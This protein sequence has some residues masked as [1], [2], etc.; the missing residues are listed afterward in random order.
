METLKIEKK[1]NEN[2]DIPK[3]VL[4]FSHYYYKPVILKT[5]AIVIKILKLPTSF[6][7]KKSLFLHMKIAKMM[8]FLNFFF[9]KL[10]CSKI[11]TA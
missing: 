11:S 9:Q 3:E 10:K 5:F 4:I 7:G 6:G 8:L 1:K 2:F